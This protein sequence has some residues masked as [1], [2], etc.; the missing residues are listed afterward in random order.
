MAFCVVLGE[1]MRNKK[2]QPHKLLQMTAINYRDIILGISL[3]STMDN[4]RKVPRTEK[5]KGT[6]R[7]CGQNHR[8]RWRPHTHMCRFPRNLY[9]QAA[10]YAPDRS[11]FFKER[12]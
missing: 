7:G 2:I 8:V 12:S 4:S 9:A 1:T 11:S 6:Q 10:L 5:T 3:D